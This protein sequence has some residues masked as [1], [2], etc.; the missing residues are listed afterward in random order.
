[1]ARSNLDKHSRLA[2]ITSTWGDGDP[3][4]NAT[5]FWQ[6]LNSDA[7]PKLDHMQFSVLA[8]GDRNYADFCGAGK[9]FDERLEKLGAKRIHPRGEC[10]V[11][12][13]AAAMAWMESLWPLLRDNPGQNG[14]SRV[15]DRN[16]S[17][18]PV[19]A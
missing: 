14:E 8:L 2:L 17:S 13:G 3:T 11:D 10:R 4:D 1:Y 15:D 12:Y 7:A 9:K 5:A 16:G 19:R 6:H 18:A